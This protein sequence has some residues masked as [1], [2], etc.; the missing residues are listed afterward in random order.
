MQLVVVHMSLHLQHPNSIVELRLNRI[1]LVRRDCFEAK[2]ARHSPLKRGA[3]RTA[4]ML[5]GIAVVRAYNRDLRVFARAVFG[6][7]VAGCLGGGC[8]EAAGRGERSVRS[9]LMRQMD[10]LLGPSPPSQS[11]A[12][13][14]LLQLAA[15]RIVSPH[16]RSRQ[17][18]ALPSQRAA[19]ISGSRAR[20]EKLLRRALRVPQAG[21]A[22]SGAK[23]C[24]YGGA[25]L[26]RVRG[27]VL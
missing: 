27:R 7:A 25:A 12:R 17:R 16:R 19:D 22:L 13:G 11:F 4:T 14:S 8:C 26:G 18:L 10:A 1:I 6:V 15:W 9:L 23:R 5:Y 3:R 20:T 21:V 2:S 24:G